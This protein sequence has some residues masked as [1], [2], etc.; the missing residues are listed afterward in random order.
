MVESINQ[1]INYHMDLFGRR[2]TSL[3]VNARCQSRNTIGVNNLTTTRPTIVNVV[4]RQLAGRSLLSML[5]LLLN[6]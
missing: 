1:S 6:N 3:K 5:S 4:A 2:R